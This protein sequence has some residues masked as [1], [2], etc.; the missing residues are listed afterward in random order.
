ME[1]HLVW[2]RESRTER[3]TEGTFR[4]GVNRGDDR[5]TGMDTHD[6]VTSSV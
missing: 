2:T 6:M 4:A 5:M 3:V 1:A